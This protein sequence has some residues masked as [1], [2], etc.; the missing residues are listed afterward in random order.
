M[1]T[2]AKTTFALLN[3]AVVVG[4]GSL[5][6]RASILVENGKIVAVGPDV[7]A[8]EGVAAIDCTGQWVMPGMIDVHTHTVMWGGEI[9]WGNILDTPDEYLMARATTYLPWWIEGGFT[10]VLDALARRDMPF[11]LR[12]AQRDGIISGPRLLVAGPAIVAT[13]ARGSFFGPREVSGWDEALK[14]AREQVSIYRSAD[15]V[16][17]MA[18]SE[19]LT[20]HVESR[21]QLTPEE[22]RATVDEAHRA[23]VPL[24]CHAYGAPGVKMAVENGVDVIV[25]GQPIGWEPGPNLA[26]GGWQSNRRIDGGR[27][28]DTD[29]SDN[30]ALLADKG[31]IWAPTLSYYELI[32]YHHW[33]EFCNVVAPFIAGRVETIAEL[34]EEN[35]RRAHQAGVRIACGTDA[36]MPFTYHGDSAYEL[37]LYVRYGM[38]T[39]EALVAATKTAAEAL[40]IDDRVGTVEAGKLADLLVL[41]TDPVADITCLQR[42]GE[43]IERVYQEGRL[44]ARN[45]MVAAPT[46][47]AVLGQLQQLQTLA[48]VLGH[49]SPY[50][51]GALGKRV[52]LPCC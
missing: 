27:F 8:P 52:V 32:R 34:L 45:G 36:G 22:V 19:V 7:R 46:R 33:D 14:A 25:H 47:E 1:T 11:E 37:E 41:N 44:V 49:R 28:A 35:F 42:K 21:V 38:S 43:V 5:L 3:A 6:P 50:L 29:Y 39:M 31:T 17:I 30:Y 4:D 15:V 2:E 20:G 26:R 13:G 24:H 51:T 12:R 48:E 16:K 40:W 9:D 10:T 18:T 23:D